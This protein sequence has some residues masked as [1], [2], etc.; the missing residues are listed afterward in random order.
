MRK[1][2]FFRPSSRGLLAWDV[3][4]LV[5]LTK[6]FPRQLIALDAVGELDKPWSGEGEAQTWRAL[7]EHVRL[8]E[9]ADLAYPIILSASGEVMDGRHRLAKAALRSETHILAVRFR[10][11]PEPD[12]VGRDPDDLPYDEVST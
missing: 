4:R 11:D 6:D 5:A 2:Y 3:D 1:Q 8:I 10:E 9:A 12:F 7:I